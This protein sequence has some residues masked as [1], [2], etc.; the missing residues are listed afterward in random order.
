MDPNAFQSSRNT[1]LRRV[2]INQFQ[3]ALLD[4]SFLAG[5]DNVDYLE[6]FY[7]DNL[8]IT[9]LPALPSLTELRLTSNTRMNEAF[10]DGGNFILQT[11]QGW[12]ISVLRIVIWRQTI[13]P[14]C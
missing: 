14:I 7:I 4:F 1:S 2:Y 5:F 13:W 8:N 12:I 3:G 6:I 11:S 9:T 10:Q